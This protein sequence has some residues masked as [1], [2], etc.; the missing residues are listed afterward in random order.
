MAEL[1]DA[2]GALDRELDQA[3]AHMH[4][5]RKVT[6]RHFDVRCDQHGR[7]Q[8]Q[9]EPMWWT[10]PGFDG[11]G[12]PCTVPF[13]EVFAGCTAGLSARGDAGSWHVSSGPELEDDLPL[14]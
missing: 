3:A 10:C 2:Y 9:P 12:C 14:L 11:E 1:G 8:Y 4:A 5:F 13:E 7:M 6:A